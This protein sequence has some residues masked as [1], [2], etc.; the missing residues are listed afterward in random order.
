MKNNIL[1]VLCALIGINNYSQEI[2]NNQAFIDKKKNKLI[3][4]VSKEVVLDKVI[5]GIGPAGISSSG[6]ASRDIISKE[7]L[8]GYPEM[9][10]IPDSLTNRKE[11]LYIL[12]DF[13]FYYQNYKQGIYS[14]DFF[15]KKAE[16]NKRNLKDTIH[17]SNKKVKN[18][19]SILAG[20]TS[21]FNCVHS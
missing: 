12:N 18:T 17:L 14:K 15:I 4:T 10:N 5:Q 1:L 13:Q 19:I 8:K 20:Y 7:E 6:I 2:K 16:G 11:Y 21:K 9:K 3:K